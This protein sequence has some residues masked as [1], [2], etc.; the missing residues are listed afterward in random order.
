MI[1]YGLPD[2]H[3]QI[4]DEPSLTVYWHNVTPKQGLIAVCYDYDLTVGKIPDSGIWLIR[5]KDHPL[6]NFV[7][8]GLLGS[9]T[10]DATT[11]RFQ[12]VP[13]DTAFQNLISQG[14]VNVILDPAISDFVESSR[15]KLPNSP[16]IFLRWENVTPRQAIVALCEDY[17]L[18][19]VKDSATGVVRIEPKK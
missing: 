17:D 10:G 16:T 9:D 5:A 18:V 1:G 2:K 4:K 3:G 8:A 6:R 14:H 11:V 19:I 7:D 15:Q 13:L 12:D